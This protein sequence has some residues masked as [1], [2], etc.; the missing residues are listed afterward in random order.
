M[1][2]AKASQP[3]VR[4]RG[5]LEA[6][7]KDQLF[8]FGVIS[9]HRQVRVVLCAHPQ[10]GM[11]F[12]SPPQRFERQTDRAYTRARRSQPIMNMGRIRL[13]LEGALEKLLCRDK[14]SA[15]EFDDPTIIERICIA[16]QSALRAQARL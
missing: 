10:I 3:E 1:A 7:S 6:R 5:S 16:R 4:Q 15:I 8:E 11:D 12:Q 13:A 2:V 14:V 9:H